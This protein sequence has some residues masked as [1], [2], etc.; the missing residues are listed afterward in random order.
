VKRLQTIVYL[1]GLSIFLFSTGGLLNLVVSDT[2]GPPN[3]S[4]SGPLLSA[5]A[6]SLVA[7]VAAATS[8]I[9]LF[10][11]DRKRTV[12]ATIT[13]CLST[14]V[15]LS[16][17]EFVA[18]WFVP[19]W[20]A[21]GLHGV[22]PEVGYTAWAHAEN[23][24]A[25]KRLNAWG[26]RDRPRTIA[27]PPGSYRIAFVG[28]SFLE[29][30]STIP[31]SLAVEQ[32]MSRR[33]VEV[34]NLGISASDPDEYFYRVR[35]IA[36][37][38]QIDHC[39]LFVFAG[40]D[41]AVRERTLDSYAGIV[42]VYP[43]DSLFSTIRLR[44]LN[45]LLT[46]DSRPV[47]RAWFAA[48]SLHERES[49]LGRTL[50]EASDQELRNKLYSFDYP[51]NRSQQQNKN[52]AARLN[53]PGMAAFFDILRHPDKNL[54]RS[55]YLSTALWSASVG[56]GQWPPLS[57]DNALY[58]VTKTRDLCHENNIAFTLVVIPE[59]F[60][61]DSRMCEQWQ[62]LTNMRQL[63]APARTAARRLVVRARRANIRTIDLHKDLER[64]PG[65]YLNLDGHWSDKGVQIVSEI[66]SQNLIKLLSSETADV[67]PALSAA[68]R[69]DQLLR[70]IPPVDLSYSVEAIEAGAI[71]THRQNSGAFDEK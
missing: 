66:L 59:A 27:R 36:V 47:L 37:P 12:F 5:L 68:G 32:K 41:F 34:L 67:F 58:W 9:F 16:S 8:G 23:A 22:P 45:Y 17:A 33:D 40:N 65:A 7:G 48:G 29:E 63:T 24:N 56:D 18:R 57:E 10:K 52:L 49:R 46:N 44:A 19:T 70:T 26:Q 14:V 55:Y 54:F 4:E 62:P 3:P 35:N 38:L 20:P 64:V 43:R 51:P 39:V 31:V 69:D 50:A 1:L 15:T 25:Q 71:N 60:Q 30:S 6:L 53:G 11:R 21:I 42:A 13:L 28:D 2:P 61:V